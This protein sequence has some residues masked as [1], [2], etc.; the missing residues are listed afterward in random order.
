MTTARSARHRTASHRLAA[1][2]ESARAESALG[3]PLPV[4]LR[5]GDGSGTGPATGPVVVRSRHALRRLWQPGESGLAQARATGE[6][7]VEGG[8]ADGPRAIRAAAREQRRSAPRLPLSDRAR[9]VGIAARLGVA[10]PPPAPPHWHAG[11]ERSA[12]A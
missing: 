1:L 7:E 11:L 6:L 4:R 2:T 9:A 8:L 12:A 5:A 3:G 10:G